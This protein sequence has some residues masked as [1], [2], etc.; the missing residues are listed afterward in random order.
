VNAPRPDKV[1]GTCQ[2]WLITCQ[3]AFGFWGQFMIMS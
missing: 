2:V 3:G 1:F